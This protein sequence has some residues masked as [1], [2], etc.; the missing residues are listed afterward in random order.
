MKE[1]DDSESEWSKQFEGMSDEE[2]LDGLRQ[3]YD[4]GRGMSV[5][6]YYELLRRREQGLDIA[7][8]STDL[9]QLV[10]AEDAKVA[11]GLASVAKNFESVVEK[12]A[13]SFKGLEIP[14]FDF[15]LPEIA[16]L[17]HSPIDIDALLVRPNPNARIVNALD[18]QN[19]KLEAIVKN[20]G[21][22]ADALV[23]R[24]EQVEEQTTVLN[25]KLD[26][27]E[28]NTSDTAGAVALR[29]EQVEVQNSVLK[30]R[31]YIATALALAGLV[32]ALISLVS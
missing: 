31:F 3:T 22:S 12:L 10:A 32:I 5:A 24:L 28:E 11:E 23:H 27:I 19:E 15:N 16:R 2:F 13:D 26:T 17:D 21:D 20:T 6:Q 29:L 30:R 9:A 14:T 8:Y 1:N 7:S 4:S 25:S 18:A